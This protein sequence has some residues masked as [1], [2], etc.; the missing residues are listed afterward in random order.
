MHLPSSSAPVA[1]VSS[2]SLR[3]AQPNAVLLRSL[4]MSLML[5][6]AA[7]QAQSSNA[8]SGSA[9]RLPT[10]GDSVSEDLDVAEERKL[11]D[12]VMREI[13]RDPDVLDD[14]LLLAYVQSLWQP[15]L[16][17][18]RRRGDIGPDLE[19]NFAWEALLIRDRS[20]N[21]FAL[22]GGYVGVH[23]GLIAVTTSRD[24]LAA[25]MGHE[26]AHITQRHIA[27]GMANASRQSL[28]GLAA[29]IAAV[30]AASRSHNPTIAQAGIVGGQA[31]MLQGQLNFSRDMEREADRVGFGVYTGAG[32]PVSGVAAMFERLESANRL[33]DNGAFPYLRTHPL[34]VE[35][36]GD[37]RARIEAAGGSKPSATSVEHD[38]MRARARVLM[39]PGVASLRAQQAAASTGA[40]AVERVP[41]LYASAL[42][43]LQLREPARALEAVQ[44]AESLLR[45]A[46]SARDAR[47][48]L[49]LR[50]AHAQALA[51]SGQ[52]ARALT[53][54]DAQDDGSRPTMLA[55]A[56]L[57]VDAA[58][59][60]ADPDA[61]LRSSL[62]A[63]QTW[64]TEHRHDALAWSQLARVSESMGLRL[65]AMRAD[66]E[67]R[68]ALGDLTGA[69][70]RLRAG[71]R[72]AREGGGGGDA[73]EAS[74]IDA[75]ARELS[76][77]HRE[78]YPDARTRP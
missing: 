14:P 19:R 75:R 33:N 63:L 17:A 6:A 35:R 57:A 65:R 78:L 73:I 71:Q 18:A 46:P 56:A 43:S 24:E 67:A 60:T 22:P 26:L 42:A 37:A 5:G 3:R 12:Q 28:V 41:L 40:G 58:R 54:L 36:I 21:A 32:H 51:M 20:V 1:V 2:P 52:G 59:G 4:L 44:A 76:A 10:L 61:L 9:T 39:D 38:M 23:L 50:I 53:A 13:R 27:R 48:G 8:G 16:A 47:A 49:A 15:L 25:V 7:A 11:G 68:A 45:A 74:V 69:I 64:V 29:M 34:T 62:E 77:L 30:A 70:D 66:A 55:R 72:L 31:L